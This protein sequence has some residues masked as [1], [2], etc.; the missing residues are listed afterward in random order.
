M[1]EMRTCSSCGSQNADD[2][3]FCAKCGAGLII[4][5]IEIGLMVFILILIIIA[6]VAALND[7]SSAM[8]ALL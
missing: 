8:I 6:I 1:D 7:T 5:W 3:L 2:Y 4:G